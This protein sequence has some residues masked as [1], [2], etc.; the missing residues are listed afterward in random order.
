MDAYKL[1]MPES[2]EEIERIVNSGTLE[3]TE[4]FDAKRELPDQR[5]NKEIAKDVAAMANNGGVLLYGVDEDANGQPTVLNPIPLAG[6]SERVQMVVHTSISEPLDVIIRER[7]LDQNKAEGY[8]LVIVPPS[9]RAPHMVISGSDYRY[10][11]RK[12]KISVPMPEGEVAR[13]Y[14]QRQRWERDVNELVEKEMARPMLPPHS[15]FAYLHLFAWALSP[16]PRLFERARGTGAPQTLL[17]DLL[18]LSSGNDIVSWSYGPDF[19]SGKPWH[20][21][22]NG[23]LCYLGSE[24]QQP[25]R[26]QY[27]Q[28]ALDIQVNDDGSARLFSGGA[29]ERRALFFAREDKVAGLTTRFVALL[30][31]LYK[32][33]TYFGSVDIAIIITNIEGVISSSVYNVNFSENNPPPYDRPEYRCVERVAAP[34]MVE[35]PRGVAERFVMP[36]VEVLTQRR[37]S[38]FPD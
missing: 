22:T 23:W 29:A 12:G 7:R 15:N 9:A 8:L 13:L 30:G 1:W 19:R 27:P 16:Q 4:I 31:N 5:K 38:P 36:W 17:D 20:R 11:E 24:P 34:T 18:R 14:Q 6:A 35:D 32:R 21:V 28:D 25:N 2:A 33:A 3:E 26:V 37:H 10:Y